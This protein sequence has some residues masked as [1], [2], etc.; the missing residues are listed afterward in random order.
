MSYEGCALLFKTQSGNRG[1][2]YRRTNVGADFPGPSLD[3]LTSFIYYIFLSTCPVN[4][5][6]H[7]SNFKSLRG[8]FEK[9]NA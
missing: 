3:R 4:G 2:M 9:T 6:E 7:K 5:H 1:K 8:M